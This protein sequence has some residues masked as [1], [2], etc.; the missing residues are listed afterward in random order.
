MSASNYAHPELLAEPDWVW[1]HQDDPNIRLI[2]CDAA[3]AYQRV[4]IPGALAFPA[5]HS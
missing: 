3:E 2:D 4:H 5:S 1:T